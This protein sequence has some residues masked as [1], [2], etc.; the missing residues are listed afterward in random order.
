MDAV[1]QSGWLEHSGTERSSWWPGEVGELPR[2]WE[3]VWVTSMEQQA[4]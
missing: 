4:L 3:G 2:P 1:A